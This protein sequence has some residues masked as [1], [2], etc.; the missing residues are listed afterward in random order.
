MDE[1]DQN[2]LPLTPVRPSAQAG[3]NVPL[4]LHRRVHAELIAQN[5]EGFLEGVCH[6]LDMVQE[7]GFDEAYEAAVATLFVSRSESR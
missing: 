6:A 5:N 7:L 3:Q 4:R 2:L 1:R